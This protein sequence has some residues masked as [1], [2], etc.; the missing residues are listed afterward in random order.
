MS[1]LRPINGLKRSVCAGDRLTLAVPSNRL[2]AM[3][4]EPRVADKRRARGSVTRANAINAAAD[5]FVTH[6]Y[7]ATSIS[8]IA[9]AAGAHSASLYHAFGSKEGILAAVV[10]H[11]SD[12]FF[13]QLVW[14]NGPV[15]LDE[16]I[17]HLQKMF[18]QRPLF[19]QM[20][21]ILVLERGSADPAL[22]A[23]AAEVRSRG[24]ALIRD[25]IARGLVDGPT[26]ATEQ[27]LDDLSRLLMIFL[28][29]ALIAR[30]VDADDA[31]LAQLFTVFGHGMRLLIA[32]HTAT[33]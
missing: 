27:L 31:V 30:Q 18:E 19:L 7:S 12:E 23:T 9:A 10:E 29:G 33:T 32:D 13:N 14:L 26:E 17:T 2:N 28:D 11:A 24:R 20:L 21:L 5:L 4:A 1:G 15:T 16:A 22:L 8:S 3:T 25:V 6:G